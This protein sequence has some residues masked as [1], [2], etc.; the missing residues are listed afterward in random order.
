[1]NVL[2]QNAW[3]TQ[4]CLKNRLHHRRRHQR[5]P[6]EHRRPAAPRTWVQRLI[7]LGVHY[8]WFHTYRP[9]APKMNPELP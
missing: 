9:S 4:T 7:D 6:D 5:L 8:V 3:R 2:Q 1:M